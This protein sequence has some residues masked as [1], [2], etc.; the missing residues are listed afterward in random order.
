MNKKQIEDF[1]QANYIEGKLNFENEAN[2]G[3]YKNQ[4][5]F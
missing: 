2:F 5:G 4:L 1:V 3:L